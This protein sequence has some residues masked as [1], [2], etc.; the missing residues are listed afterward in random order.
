MTTKNSERSSHPTRRQFVGGVLGG[1][2]AGL[3]A[4]RWS[5]VSAQSSNVVVW[6]GEGG[7]KVL[8]DELR[9]ARDGRDV[10]NSVWDGSVVRQAGARNETVN[11]VLILE[12]PGG[13]ASVDVALSPLVG[14]GGYAIESRSASG[15]DLFNF[16]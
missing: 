11:A 7:D 14:P 13:A 16:V 4:G 2:G 6:A 12:S 3:S 15:D 9:V 1:L 8:Q 5:A 10:R